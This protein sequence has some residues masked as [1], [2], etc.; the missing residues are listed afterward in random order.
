MLKSL[1]SLLFSLRHEPFDLRSPLQ[2]KIGASCFSR[3]QVP[4]MSLLLL[5]QESCG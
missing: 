3:R 2:M 5:G 1:K 4:E